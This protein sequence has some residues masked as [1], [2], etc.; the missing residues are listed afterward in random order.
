VKTRMKE[1]TAEDHE[2]WVDTLGTRRE[3]C[4]EYRAGLK[5]YCGALIL[6]KIGPDDREDCLRAQEDA[7]DEMPEGVTPEQRL[8]RMAAET[9]NVIADKGGLLKEVLAATAE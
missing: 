9:A 4:R 7:D 6:F 3:R 8:A 1:L 5:A 2:S